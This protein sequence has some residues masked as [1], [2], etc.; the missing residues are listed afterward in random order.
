MRNSLLAIATATAT[1]F[2]QPQIVL[3]QEEAQDTLD[4]ASHAREITVQV[5]HPNN[6]PGS[7][8]IVGK[9]GNVYYVL[10]A[11]HVVNGE[12]ALEQAS[13]FFLVTSDGE[14]HTLESTQVLLS[15]QNKDLALI[16][17]TSDRPYPEAV[18]SEYNYPLYERRD[19]EANTVSDVSENKNYLY[20]TGFPLGRDS[21]QDC[22]VAEPPESCTEAVV[23]PGYLFDNSGSAISSPDIADPKDNFGGYEL[24]YTNLTHV[25]MSGGPVLDTEGRLIGIHGRADA[26]VIG[27]EDE[28][29]RRYLD[30]NGG[31]NAKIELGLSLG[32][33]IKSFLSWVEVEPVNDYLIVEDTAPIEVE[34]T[35]VAA[36]LPP[37]SLSK[38]RT[39]P[40]YLIER[41]NQLWRV[42]DTVNARG[43]FENA[44]AQQEDL[45]LAW[46]AKGFVS[47]FDELYDRALDACSRAIE[48]NVTPND[49]KYESHRCKAGA[50]QQLNRPEEALIALEEAIAIDSSNQNPADFMFQGEL[51]FA[52]GKH[53]EALA[54]L[55][56]AVNLRTEQELSP[57]PVLY[58]NRALV[59]LELGQPDA[60]LTDTDEAIAID[61]NFAPAYRNQGLILETS[62]RNKES[63]ELYDRALELDS[64][65]YNTWT[66]KGFALYKLQ[67]I[68]EAKQAFERAIELNPDYQPA[69]SNLE[70][71]G[72]SN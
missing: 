51:L 45:Y 65:D 7:G 70:A 10:T 25:G 26:R 54:S 19:Y 21:W 67:R 50:L 36:T 35:E 39:N 69:I 44:I 3:S 30:E 4:I 41:G 16:Q 68:D 33:P 71:I 64:E 38:D 72:G 12:I 66:N 37:L 49:I 57:S 11:G 56:N 8:V 48:L 24:I 17:F 13:S 55:D 5:F 15:P 53:Q 43:S 22:Q 62:D 47:G 31:S 52:L 1:A 58:N 27:E 59:K 42:G 29:I 40:Y 2:V 14:E 34:S 46:Y 28:I 6:E 63:L 61:P 9:N 32:I 18:I 20:V 23:N 60:A